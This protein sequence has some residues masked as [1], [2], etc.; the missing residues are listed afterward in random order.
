MRGLIGN[1]FLIA[2]LAHGLIGVSL[3]W[4]TVLLRQPD[5]RNVVSY[6]FWLGALSI[7]GQLLI[8]FG[9]RVSAPGKPRRR[10]PS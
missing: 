10:S 7:L 8:P 4:D 1:G 3:V 5:T 9:F 2:L 6:V